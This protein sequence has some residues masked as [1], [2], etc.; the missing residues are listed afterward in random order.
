MS[1]QIS[2]KAYATVWGRVRELAGPITP[3]SI[4]AIPR[5]ELKACGL[6]FKKTDWIRS[7]A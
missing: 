6:S 3:G 5:E 4:L 1:Q 7:G 2:K